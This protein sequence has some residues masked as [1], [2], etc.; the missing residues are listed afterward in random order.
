MM[1]N[2]LRNPMETL[3]QVFSSGHK[4]S[5]NTQ[6]TKDVL[7]KSRPMTLSESYSRSLDRIDLDALFMR[8]RRNVWRELQS[9]ESRKGRALATR[10]SGRMASGQPY[11]YI[12]PFNQKGWLFERSDT[13]WVICFAEKIHTADTFIRSE[14]AWDVATCLTNQSYEATPR[15]NSTK[16]ELQLVSLSLYEDKVISTVLGEMI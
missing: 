4:A 16:F 14:Y 5:E 13:G 8:F 15:V 2:F 9:L 3:K 10:E 12:K 7:V 6:K 1:K 11:F